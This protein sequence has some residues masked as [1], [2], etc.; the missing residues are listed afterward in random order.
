MARDE[1]QL[2]LREIAIEDVEV[3]PAYAA[4]KD[5]YGDLARPGGRLRE[6][7]ELQGLTL[8]VEEHGAHVRG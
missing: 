3:S 2:G 1:G 6:V 5:A 8:L 4:G 7:L